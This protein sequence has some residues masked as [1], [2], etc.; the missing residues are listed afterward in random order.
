MDFMGVL[1]IGR[2]VYYTKKERYR[3]GNDSAGL[4]AADGYIWKLPD[5]SR[6]AGTCTDIGDGKGAL[7][8]R[9]VD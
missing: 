2:S 6:G 4:G 8:G 3:C 1:R 9:L 5:N 7:Y